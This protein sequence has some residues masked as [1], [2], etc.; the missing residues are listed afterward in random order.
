MRNAYSYRADPSV[1]PF[2]DDRP[3]FVFDGFCALCSASAQ[4]VMRHDPQARFRLLAAQSPL[5]QA[6]YR[7]Y[8]LDPERLDSVILLTGGRA[9]LRSDAALLIATTIGWPWRFAASLRLLPRPVRDAAYDL[10][11]RNRFRLFGRR[12]TC[13]RPTPDQAARFLA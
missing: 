7:H 9:Y 1:P 8:G 12:E 5:G 10:V 4:F 11:A 13:H 6:L 2:A 3:V